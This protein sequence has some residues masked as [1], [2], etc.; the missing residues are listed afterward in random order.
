MEI[1]SHR[2][3]LN[4]PSPLEENTIKAI[5][6]AFALGFSV[7]FDIRYHDVDFWLGHDSAQERI[8]FYLL[9]ELTN[10]YKGNMYIHCKTIETL[11]HLIARYFTPRGMKQLFNSVV[12]KRWIPFFHDSDDCILL[13]NNLIWAHPKT[14]S[15]ALYMQHETIMVDS[16][17]KLFGNVTPEFRGFCTDYPISLNDSFIR[18]IDLT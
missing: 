1:I 4:G 9:D 16:D 17:M 5:T 3:N 13:N 10:T 12:N 6:D 8:D 15:R 18:G 2:G 11:Q 14:K 7:E